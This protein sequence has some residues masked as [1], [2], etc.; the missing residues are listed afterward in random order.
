LAL[1]SIRGYACFYVSM[2][3]LHIP[4]DSGR[5]RSNCGILRY[6]IESDIPV[7]KSSGGL[8]YSN[9]R[10]PRLSAG[11]LVVQLQFPVFPDQVIKKRHRRGCNR[12]STVT[13]GSES[14]ALTFTW[15]CCETLWRWC[16]RI[17]CY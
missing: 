4:F 8:S 10:L 17:K 12:S 14:V 16:T 13:F 3:V 15:S 5:I 9:C 11:K 1:I 2:D 7:K 6:P